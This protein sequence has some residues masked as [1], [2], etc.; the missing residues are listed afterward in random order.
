MEVSDQLQASADVP[1]RKTPPT[2]GYPL[3][4]V[5]QV[6]QLVYRSALRK[7]L[8]RTQMRRESCLYMECIRELQVVR[9]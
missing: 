2:P 8:G 7:I 9:Q 3:E 6:P 5:A 1:R 4:Y